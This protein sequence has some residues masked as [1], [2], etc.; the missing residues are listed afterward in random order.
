MAERSPIIT[1]GLE[2]KTFD[3][4]GLLDVKPEAVVMV[5]P[6]EA[7][8]TQD[9][10]ID[11]LNPYTAQSLT[12]ALERWNTEMPAAL[13]FSTDGRNYE[14]VRAFS[15]RW[16]VS[17]VNFPRVTARYFR[18]KL[19][20]LDPAGDWVFQRFAKEIPLS[21]S[22]LLPTTTLEYVSGKAAY[23]RQDV[24][25]TGP[26]GSPEW[27]VPQSQIVDLSSEMTSDGRLN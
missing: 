6:P 4:A 3:A 21:H 22:E 2:R 11:F 25:T 1:Y 24:F 23:T 19:A 17:S 16:P 8:L 7:G 9:L 18:I 27:V 26:P 13:E 20:I 15:T 14:T 10:N 5:P 12:I